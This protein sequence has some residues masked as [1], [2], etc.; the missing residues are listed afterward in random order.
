MPPDPFD[1]VDNP[2]DNVPVVL[3][4]WYVVVPLVAIVP[5][6]PAVAVETIAGTLTLRVVDTVLV[7]TGAE[8]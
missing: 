1:D 7:A 4:A 5:L 2:I 6:P 3:P 8:E